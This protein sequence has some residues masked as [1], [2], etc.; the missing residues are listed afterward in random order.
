MSSKNSDFLLDFYLLTWD[1]LFTHLRDKEQKW[2][3]A[4]VG[5]GHR[6]WFVVGEWSREREQQ[7]PPLSKGSW[8][9]QEADA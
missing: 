2:E 4:Q 9:M 5:E 3:K 7:A 6:G 8:L 1:I